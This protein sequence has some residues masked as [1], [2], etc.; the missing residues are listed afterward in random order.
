MCLRCWER[1]HRHFDA[2]ECLLYR[3]KSLIVSCLYRWEL[4]E[5]NPSLD[6]Y[7]E[8]DRSFPSSWSVL[9]WCF[10]LYTGGKPLMHV[11]CC[12]SGTPQWISGSDLERSSSFLTWIYKTRTT[13]SA[14]LARDNR[15]G[16]P[17]VKSV[18]TR[19]EE[20]HSSDWRHAWRMSVT[21]MWP[22]HLRLTP[23]FFV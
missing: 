13:I 6:Q 14:W 21:A 15:E 1:N 23:R 12:L 17:T 2:L 10:F 5:S 20:V 3:L 4:K 19:R 22:N 11:G 8:K 9:F 7:L 16:T 18:A